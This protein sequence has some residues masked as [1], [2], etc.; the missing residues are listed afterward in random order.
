MYFIGKNV[1]VLLVYVPAFFKR[2]SCTLVPSDIFPLFPCSAKPLGDPACC[3]K[4]FEFFK[5]ASFT[6]KHLQH[7]FTRYS[8]LC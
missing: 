5:I 8:H 1:H 4:F 2:E 3:K 7:T 6:K